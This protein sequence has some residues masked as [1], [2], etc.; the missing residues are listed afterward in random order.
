[1][2][3]EEIWNDL[4]RAKNPK[5]MSQKETILSSQMMKEFDA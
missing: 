1:L 5:D 3:L 2:V 4:K